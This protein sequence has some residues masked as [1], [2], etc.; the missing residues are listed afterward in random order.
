[1][2]NFN[3]NFLNCGLIKNDQEYSFI[4]EWLSKNKIYI[5]TMLKFLEVSSARHSDFLFIN[6]KY[7]NV[8]NFW[9]QSKLEEIEKLMAQ[10]IEWHKNMFKNVEK[11]IYQMRKIRESVSRYIMTDKHGTKFILHKN[12]PKIRRIL[13]IDHLSPEE[14]FMIN[15]L[16][17]YNEII[18]KKFDIIYDE[19]MRSKSTLN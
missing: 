10:S 5:N 1:M 16:K 8:K 15:G 17:E 6:E 3:Q 12:L 4:F 14:C 18:I 11:T 19:C 2:N 7:K 13:D 9:T